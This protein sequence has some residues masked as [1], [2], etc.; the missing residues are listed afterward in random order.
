MLN[1]CPGAPG[2]GGTYHLFHTQLWKPTVHFDTLDITFFVD[3][4][5]VKQPL[6]E[7]AKSSPIDPRVTCESYCEVLFS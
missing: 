1:Y 3:I 7:E 4:E 2:S 6:E 5:I